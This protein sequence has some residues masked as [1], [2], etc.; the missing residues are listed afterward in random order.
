MVI[1]NMF[2]DIFY[3]PIL[4]IEKNLIKRGFITTGTQLHA[5]T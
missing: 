5:K 3:L 2:S 1:Q 4:M